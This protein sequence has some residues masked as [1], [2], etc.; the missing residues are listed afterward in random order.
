MLRCRVAVFRFGEG[1]GR[2]LERAA[3][4]FFFTKQ[5]NK[6]QLS[7]LFFLPTCFSL[8]GSTSSLNVHDG[9]TEV[10]AITTLH[11]V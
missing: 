4:F 2:V 8:K 11:T 5:A 7:S 6:I 10:F 1:Y 3:H 9:N